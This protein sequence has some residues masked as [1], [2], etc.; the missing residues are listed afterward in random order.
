MTRGKA[1]LL[2][3]VAAAAVAL[4][5]FSRRASEPP[6]V[7]LA[8][9][10]IAGALLKGATDFHEATGL[11]LAVV[12]GRLA[13]L[14]NTSPKPDLV[15]TEKS[16]DLDA[17]FSSGVITGE[18]QEVARNRLVFATA[19]PE[20]LA[21]AKD[22][23]S[24]FAGGKL[25]TGDPE[26]T[27]LGTAAREALVNL[28]FPGDVANYIEPAPSAREALAW[29][30]QQKALEGILYRSDARA[31]DGITVLDEIPENAHT[32]IAYLA[33]P[34]AEGDGRRA[35]LLL[36]FLKSEP[37]KTILTDNGFDLPPEGGADDNGE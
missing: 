25:V 31:D 24:F 37:F 15:V 22:G 1:I 28:G 9:P 30:K 16:A 3:A 17:V 13:D 11:D 18:P 32:P 10:S 12:E 33:A 14:G 2:L 19:N 34:L 21:A 26:T 23:T 5:L 7:V 35:S 27:A 4:F 36:D 6:V 8:S 20:A 29:L